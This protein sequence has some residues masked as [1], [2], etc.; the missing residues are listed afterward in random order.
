MDNE[1]IQIEKKFKEFILWNKPRNK[2]FIALI[3]HIKALD[4]VSI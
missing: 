1:N 3:Q 4:I 2:K